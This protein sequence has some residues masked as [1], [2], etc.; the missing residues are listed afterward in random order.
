MTL[1]RPIIQ[2]KFSC[3]AKYEI[4]SKLLQ[5]ANQPPCKMS[6]STQELSFLFNMSY[7]SLK[8]VCLSVSVVSASAFQCLSSRSRVCLIL[9]VLPDV[10]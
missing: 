9:L 8:V 2:V 5:F 4:R 7:L 6:I 1:V 3:P 10:F